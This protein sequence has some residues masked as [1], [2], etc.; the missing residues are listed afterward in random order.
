MIGG[1]Y[2]A[3]SAV[4]GQLKHP[5][6][7]KFFISTSYL[8][9][10][11]A[12]TIFQTFG[13][14]SGAQEPSLVICQHSI[15]AQLKIYFGSTQNLCKYFATTPKT[16]MLDFNSN[17]SKLPGII[18]AKKYYFKKHICSQF[19]GF[20]FICFPTTNNKAMLVRKE[21]P[22][23]LQKMDKALFWHFLPFQI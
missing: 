21:L 16:E 3:V 23:F 2:R 20:P 14:C 12:N 1:R 8:F 9:R 13:P 18:S 19:S 5:V 22:D 6:C 7:D 15:L 17:S 4:A 11:S 10:Y